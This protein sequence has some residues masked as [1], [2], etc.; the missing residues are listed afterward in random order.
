MSEKAELRNHYR[1][2]R[3]ALPDRGHRSDV[4]FVRVEQLPA[5]A[6]AATVMVYDSVPGEVETAAFID[7]LRRQGRTVLL[8]E[9]EPPPDPAVPDLIVVPGIAFCSDGRR[10]GQGGGWYDRFLSQVRPGCVTVGVCF[11]ELLVDELPI[12]PHDVR[13]DVIVTDG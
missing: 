2:V 7:R 4:V 1:A 3:R 13:V 6:A 11:D 12:E 8:P 5:F 10:L 9:D